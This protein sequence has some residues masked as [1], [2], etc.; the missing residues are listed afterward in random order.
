MANRELDIAALRADTPA[1]GAINHLNNAGSALPPQQ[2]VAASIDHLN[3]EAAIGGYEA[4][5]QRADAIARVPHS[6]AALLSCR[7]DQVAIVESATTAWDRGLQAIALAE[8]FGPRD[9]FLVSAAEYA[10]NVL[11]LYQLTRRFGCRVEF[12]PDAADGS[13]DIEAFTAMLDEDVRIVSITHAASHNGVVN[14]VVA[15]GDALRY[16]GS[17]SWYL[18]DACQSIGQLDVDASRIG[19]D[20]ISATG[21][22][23]LRGPRG[24][25]FLVA[26]DR[27]LH[28]IEPF[29]LDLHSATWTGDGTYTIQ[30]GAR[31]FETWEHS[32]SAVLGLGAAV[33]YALECG[34]PAI[35]QRI[36]HLADTLRSGLARI[37]GASVHDRG[38]Q[39]SGIVTV[40]F[41]QVPA[42]QLVPKLREN[43]I[44]TSLSS[45][46][47]APLDFA[48]EG[49]TS[50]V[51]LSPH[52]YN[53]EEEIDS[54]LSTLRGLVSV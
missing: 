26:S 2:V 16:S 51:R 37:P 47:Y 54:V 48:R 40:S 53:T 23:F 28:D 42:D 38:D 33:D 30:A 24:T 31:R 36:Q 29:P 50:K 27:I 19:A 18:V 43:G 3:L 9:R 21:R 34:I 44:N 22:K 52:A 32:Y 49:V 25:G 39:R 7:A 17:A 12:I 41:E 6:I 15:I 4:H 11:P 1:S 13:T 46:D 14:D 20:I 10:S 8:D 35:Q 5:A 45:A